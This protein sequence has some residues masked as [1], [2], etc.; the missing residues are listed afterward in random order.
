MTESSTETFNQYSELES[1]NLITPERLVS[2]A[3]G[4]SLEEA[5]AEVELAQSRKPQT[6]DA[7]LTE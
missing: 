2:W 7:L 5:K 1:R 4:M 6:V 3:T